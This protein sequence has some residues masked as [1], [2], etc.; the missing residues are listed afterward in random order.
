MHKAIITL[1]E[2]VTQD[3]LRNRKSLKNQCNYGAAELCRRAEAI[4]ISLKIQGGLW[5]GRIEHNWCV[6]PNGLI[7]DPTA[8]QFDGGVNG[9][10]TSATAPSYV[11]VNP[12][13]VEIYSRLAETQGWN[14]GH[15]EGISQIAI[16]YGIYGE[17]TQILEEFKKFYP[18][19]CHQV[20]DERKDDLKI[21]KNGLF[22]AVIRLGGVQFYLDVEGVVRGRNNTFMTYPQTRSFVVFKNESSYLVQEI[23]QRLYVTPSGKTGLITSRG[24]KTRI[25]LSKAGNLYRSYGKNQ[26]FNE[27]L[28]V[29]DPFSK[30]IAQLEEMIKE[31]K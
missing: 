6:D 7:Y 5:Q 16:G 30:L 21:A 10:Q 20:I 2:E 25:K 12:T 29:D 31:V 8:E 9:L 13:Q 4:G 14:K 3:I 19:L 11:T 24:P 23:E 18:D 15:T 28:D 1:S 22:Y 17:R 27:R 26:P